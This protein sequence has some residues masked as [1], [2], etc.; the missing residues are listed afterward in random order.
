M[1]LLGSMRLADTL[2]GRNPRITTFVMYAYNVNDEINYLLSGAGFL[3]SKGVMGKV[4][5][6]HRNVR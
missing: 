4:V 3:P 6:K 1:F 2:D 5:R